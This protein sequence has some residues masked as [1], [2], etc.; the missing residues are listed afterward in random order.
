[1]THE[2]WRPVVGFEGLYEVSNLGR[3]RSL[4]RVVTSCGSQKGPYLRRLK[5]RIIKP[6]VGT[7]RYLYVNLHAE[8]DVY[9]RPAIHVLVARAFIGERPDGKVVCHNDGRRTNCEAANLRY[10]TTEENAVDTHAHGTS[11]LGEKNP[12]SKLT[13]A[14]I[15]QIRKLCRK[16]MYQRDVAAR[17]EV[18]QSLVSLIA[19][20]KVWRHV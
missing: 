14:D 17:F 8:N 18:A 2:E 6:L 5:G 3:V 11:L 7:D 12:A 9:R 20:N 10:D 1:M 16:G 13:A 19:N 15:T 4:D